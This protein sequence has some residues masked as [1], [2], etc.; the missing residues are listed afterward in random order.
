ML[1]VNG[2]TLK[3]AVKKWAKDNPNKQVKCDLLVRLREKN[4]KIPEYK[5][6]SGEELMRCLTV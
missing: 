2:Y 6:W 5:Y 4:T 3:S 1:E